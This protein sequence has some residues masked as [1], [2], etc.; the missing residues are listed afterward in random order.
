[1]IYQHPG[2]A[3]WLLSDHLL[4]ADFPLK[5][6]RLYNPSASALWLLLIKGQ[7]DRN[8]LIA[9]YAEVFKLPLLQARTDV[10]ACLSEWAT[11]GW[12]DNHGAGCLR[13]DPKPASESLA[14][15]TTDRAQ[16]PAHRVLLDGV[17]QL[18]AT[19]FAVR[20]GELDG[21]DLSPSAN[22]TL[23]ARISA[24]LS[25]FP[26]ART[27]ATTSMPQLLVAVAPDVTYIDDGSALSIKDD[28]V[29]ALGQV[30]LAVFRMAYPQE[31]MLGTLHAAAVGQRGT[32]LLSGVSGAG[33]STL[34]SYL[35]SKGW[36]YYGDDI[37]GLNAKGEVLS[38]PASV[39]LKE[40]SWSALRP[41]FPQLEGL[42][43]MSAGL[44]TVRYLPLSS[45]AT[46]EAP[47]R[48]VAAWVFPRYVAQAQTRF[49]AMDAI[50]ALQ[51][52]IGSGFS[53]DGQYGYKGVG[54]FV[55][56]LTGAPRYRLLYSDL[57]EAE[58]CLQSLL[59]P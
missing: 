27:T 24:M 8:G 28:A 34:A 22:S 15:S 39:S 58:E 5:Y 26:A 32:L 11:L 44:K 46:A 48:K 30:I 19:S 33:K 9:A 2:L 17:F 29:D 52:L 54:Q 7:L 49:E 37:V 25:G 21:T 3:A 50:E 6:L 38:F 18:G 53:L 35:F 40:G 47:A 31:Q 23:A 51:S 4:V 36:A 59:T 20:V 56:L 16:I 10:M 41:S 42:Q 55:S 43:S 57:K 13:I 45:E 1:M 12:L 14:D